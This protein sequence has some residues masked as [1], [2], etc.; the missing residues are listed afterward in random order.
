MKIWTYILTITV[1]FLSVKPGIDTITFS[2]ENQQTCCLKTKYSPISE[3]QESDNK[4]DQ[5]T[6]G[7][8]NPLQACCSCNLV[9]VG[10]LFFPSLKIGIS[11]EP[12][13]GYPSLFSSKFI[14]DFW[15]PP[16]FV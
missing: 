1:I 16:Q 9:Y 8:C 14:S 12:Y 5:E 6:K 4:N 10:S 2:S 3:N 7:V 15:Q 13:F 11:Y